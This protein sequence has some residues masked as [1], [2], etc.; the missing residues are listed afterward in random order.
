MKTM[1]TQVLLKR[2]HHSKVVTFS[3]QGSSLNVSWLSPIG[4]HNHVA[5]K[6][7]LNWQATNYFSHD[8]ETTIK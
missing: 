6:F 3:V 1:V 4:Y 5:V 7:L 2:Q 8:V